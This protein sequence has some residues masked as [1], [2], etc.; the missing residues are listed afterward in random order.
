[1]RALVVMLVAGGLLAA[2]SDKAEEAAQRNAI[3]N[4]TPPSVTSRADY[5]GVI[6][7]RFQRLDKNNDLR[8]ERGELPE[9]RA[10]QLLRQ[11]DADNSG[12]LDSEEWGKYMLE[13]FDRLD[14]NKDG[15]ITSDERKAGRGDRGDRGERAGRNGR[16]ADAGANDQTREERRAARRERRENRD[17]QDAGRD[18]LD[19]ALDEASNVAN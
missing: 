12:A 2:C 4:F 7:R 9:R 15:S 6:E 18:D 14:T 17:G 16:D 19:S 13:R 5:G 1:M 3:T 10:D 8:L 11:Y